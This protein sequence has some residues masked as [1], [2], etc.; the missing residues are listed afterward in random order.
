MEIEL[1]PP[2]EVGVKLLNCW[3]V[4]SGEPDKNHVGVWVAVDPVL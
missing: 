4:S 3:G 1:N 2:G